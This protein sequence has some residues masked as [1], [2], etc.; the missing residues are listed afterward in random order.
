MH[1]TFSL[2]LQQKSAYYNDIFNRLILVNAK[3]RDVICSQSYVEMGVNLCENL[4]TN[5]SKIW[6][7]GHKNSVLP[8][9]FWII[10][11]NC[12]LLYFYDFNISCKER[13]RNV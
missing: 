8:H 5:F 1:G 6:S 12:C 3:Y 13:E 9:V 2:E 11:R 10:Q 4:Y 7:V